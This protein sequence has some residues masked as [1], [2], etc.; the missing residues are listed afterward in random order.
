MSTD[1]RLCPQCG[2]LDFECSTKE[3]AE[4]DDSGSDICPKCVRGWA[5]AATP[6]PFQPRCAGCGR[7]TPALRAGVCSKCR[8]K[9]VSAPGLPF[10]G[11]DAA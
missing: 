7:R 8:A 4:W 10:D 1:R 5:K 9:G 2:K 11:G 6:P 3:L